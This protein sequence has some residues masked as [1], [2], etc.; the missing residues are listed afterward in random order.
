MEYN[1]EIVSMIIMKSIIM[2]VYVI[3]LV[4]GI[5]WLSTRKNW[6]GKHLPT[7]L[8]WVTIGLVIHFLI[9]TKFFSED[10]STCIVV[11]I[12]AFGI[13]LFPLPNKIEDDKK[14]T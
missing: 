14:I 12:T 3:G 4:L 10:T 9:L 1:P 11:F 13:N 8:V 7:I 5:K 6:L 2:L